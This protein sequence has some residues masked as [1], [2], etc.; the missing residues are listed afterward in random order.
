M[1]GFAD[2]YLCVM[3]TAYALL[4]SHSYAGNFAFHTAFHT[5]IRHACTRSSRVK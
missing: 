1:Q 4:K 3:L 2:I 5:D